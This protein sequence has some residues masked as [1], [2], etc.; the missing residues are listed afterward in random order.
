M[1]MDGRI[2]SQDGPFVIGRLIGN[3]NAQRV[4]LDRF[5]GAW[6]SIISTFPPMLIRRT[7]GTLWT[8]NRYASEIHTFFDGKTVKHADKALAQQ[9]ENLDAMSAFRARAEAD[10]AA[11]LS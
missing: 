1:A 4:V 5:M 2:K 10:L 9:L 11:Y 7:L 6:D 3:K 8:A